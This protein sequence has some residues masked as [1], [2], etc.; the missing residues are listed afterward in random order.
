MNLNAVV[1]A[2]HVLVI[3]GLMCKNLEDICYC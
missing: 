1:T 2:L 3:S